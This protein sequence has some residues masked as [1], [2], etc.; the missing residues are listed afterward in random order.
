MRYDKKTVGALFVLLVV[1]AMASIAFVTQPSIL[2]TDPAT[3]VIV[4][5]V[6]APVLAAF[7]FKDRFD[8]SIKRRDVLLGVAAFV[9][10][11]L[12]TIWLRLYLSYEFLGY[13]VEFLLLPF[14]VAA[15]AFLM[16]G[17]R[18]IGRFKV[19]LLYLLLGSPIL[20]MP[21]IGQNQNF[22]V[23]NTV[24]IYNIARL[25]IANMA[26]D[27][28]ITISANGYNVSIG[29]TCVGVGALIGL[30]MF[31]IPL[32]YFYNGRTVRKLA[33]I[34]SGFLMLLA[35][36]LLRM[37]MISM[38]WLFYGPSN[39]I[40][41]IHVFAGVLIFYITIIVM[42]L[43]AG[44]Y[45]LDIPTLKNERF[46]IKHSYYGYGLALSAVFALICLAASIDYVNAIVVSPT[47]LA[48]Y[49]PVNYSNQ[50]FIGYTGSLLNMLDAN[51]SATT[52]N[53]GTGEVF[54]LFNNTIP[55]SDP[56][57][58]FFNNENIS[59]R[60]ILAGNASISGYYLFMS[61]TGISGQVYLANYQNSQE[62][63]FRTVLPYV[64]DTRPFSSMG[65]Y[66]IMPSYIIGSNLTC[67][68]YDKIYTDLANAANPYAYSA[69]FRAHAY[70]AYC[71]AEGILGG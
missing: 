55:S 44:K 36:N 33:W 53:N 49:T 71:F 2:D 31:L 3:Y 58:A 61:N 38:G 19:L 34:G 48:T 45:G 1:A 39:A 67:N 70:N 9:V 37:L 66:I 27:S 63:V 8:V 21:L 29:E 6:M 17:S 50:Y 14:L 41:V 51:E 46:Q 4:P 52:L 11:L 60:P 57:V 35:L 12:A 56:V 62:Y 13:G 69:T 68:S 7:A 5:L 47:Y 42:V 25:F 40:L 18:N 24:V 23:A 32:A 15:M 65:V 20:F 54:I 16:F 64:S 28:A 26:Y 43:I 30:V 59:S 10:F 22:A